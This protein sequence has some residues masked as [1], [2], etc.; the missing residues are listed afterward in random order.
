MLRWLLDHGSPGRDSGSAPVRQPSGVPG[1]D[2]IL[3]QDETET[4]KSGRA[5]YPADLGYAGGQL[6]EEHT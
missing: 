1:D 3:V 2:P 5:A 6:L 4:G